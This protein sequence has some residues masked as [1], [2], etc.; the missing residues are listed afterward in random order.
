VTDNSAA[1]RRAR[2]H[3]S[4]TK[5]QRAADTIRLLEDSGE[6]I[7]F[8]A[9]ARRA[10]VSVSLLYANPDLASRIAAARD[11]QRQAGHNRAWRLPARSLV[12]E[13]S[14]RADLANAHEQNSRLAQEVAALRSRLEHHLGAQADIAR[15]QSTG[16]LL[17]QLEQ[18]AA[19]L[20]ADKSRLGHEVSRLQAEASELADTLDA[21]RAMN[22]ELMNELNRQE[23]PAEQDR[24]GATRP[25]KN[26]RTSRRV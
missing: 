18:R 21:A 20:E 5:R 4:Q 13:Q 19:E 17:D 2:R 26:G 1:L 14:L 3:D 16:P 24:Q 10:G 9:V 7:T 6:P 8:P 23:R 22:R 25:S 12:T 11:R 15:G